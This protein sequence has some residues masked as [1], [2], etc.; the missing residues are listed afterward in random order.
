MRWAT[1]VLATALLAALALSGCI[2]FGG[3][4]D[5]ASPDGADDP[6]GNETDDG[7]ETGEENESRDNATRDGNETSDEQEASWTYDNRTGSVQGANAI[8][9]TSDSAEETFDVGPDTLEL[10]LGLGAEGGELEMCIQKPSEDENGTGDDCDETVTTED[11]NA[12]FSA[13]EP[14]EGEWTVS[15][16]PAEPGY[17][18]IDYELAIAQLVPTGRR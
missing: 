8:V 17:H 11:G 15:L 5:D 1:L 7:N 9:G 13:G 2:G 16:S 3:E 6:Y 12:S 18:S 4:D 10:G 14:A